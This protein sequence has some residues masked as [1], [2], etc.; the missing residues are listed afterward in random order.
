MLPALKRLAKRLLGRPVVP[1]VQG[2][3][4]ASWYDAAYKAIDTYHAPYRNSHYYFLWCVLADRIRA[5]KHRAVL[6]IGCGPGQFAHC[7]FDLAGIERY[8]GLDFSSHAVSLA[9]SLAAKHFPDR[10]W[11]HVDDAT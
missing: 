9:A 1:P 10:A 6:D 7:L 5:G 3:A 11:F 4:D 2:V 8:V